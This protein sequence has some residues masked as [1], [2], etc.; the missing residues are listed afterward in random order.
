M[1]KIIVTSDKYSFCLDGLQTQMT[2]YWKEDD[3]E[4]TVLGFNQPRATLGDNYK[5]VQAGK[6]FSDRTPWR[7]ALN[8]FFR[9][10]DEDY[11]FLA[12]EDHYL[13]D[14]VN[15]DLLNKAITIMEND[16]NVGKVRLL[17]KYKFRA[18]DPRNL[19]NDLES[20]DD[21]FYVAPKVHGIYVHSSLRPSIWRK[22][23]FLKQLNNPRGV[24]NPHNFETINNSN[25][26]TEIVI[27]PKQEYPIYP[28]IDAM[29]MGKPNVVVMTHGHKPM[30]Y[31]DLTLKEE[32]LGVF[33]EVKRIW[34]GK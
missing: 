10:L 33:S 27:L 15:M 30:D 26:F 8:P 34:G 32:D 5:F 19:F 7:E 3:L 22:D 20:Y 31:Y 28:D 6:G 17:P 18:N 4:F 29:R 16:S 23:F 11:F 13:I 14:D 24:T 21:D 2:K 25:V 12:F 1:K 9:T